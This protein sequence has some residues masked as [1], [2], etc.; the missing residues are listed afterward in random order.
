MS[1]PSLSIYIYWCAKHCRRP[2]KKDK[3]WTCAERYPYLA[4]LD[5]ADSKPKNSIRWHTA[6]QGDKTLSFLGMNRHRCAE[7]LGLDV[8]IARYGHQAGFPDI[9]NHMSEFDDFRVEVP[10]QENPL[11]IL[12]C[13]EDRFCNAFCYCFRCRRGSFLV[14]FWW[15]LVSWVGPRTPLGPL[16][17][18]I[19]IFHDF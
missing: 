11:T 8:Y 2:L 1:Y 14:S 19:R 13:P 7:I 10:F 3:D 6:L 15:Y 12:C 16:G 9:R 4:S 17:G 18:Q 5:K